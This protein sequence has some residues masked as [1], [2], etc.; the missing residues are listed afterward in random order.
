MQM[1]LSFVVIEFINRWIPQE[2]YLKKSTFL[3]ERSLEQRKRK[4]YLK[5]FLCPGLESK[6]CDYRSLHRRDYLR[7][8]IK[9]D[10]DK[11]LDKR[12]RKRSFRWKLRQKMF[13]FFPFVHW[14]FKIC[15]FRKFPAA[16]EWI[17]LGHYFS[18]F[19][20]IS[21]GFIIIIHV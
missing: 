2:Q 7:N 11:A 3:R 14:T 10:K 13:S 17:S 21:N 18:I 4:S 6:L 15:L 5:W 1:N 9:V 20:V 19:K 16:L 8:Q 12:E